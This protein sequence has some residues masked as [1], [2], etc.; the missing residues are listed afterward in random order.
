MNNDEKSPKLDLGKAWYAMKKHR[1]LY[2]R[3]LP[4]TTIVVMILSLGYPNYYRCKVTLVPEIETIDS[5]RNLGT[6][7]SF[8]RSLGIH[9]SRGNDAI[10][11]DMYPNL[12]MT[13]DFTS[14]MFDIR[15]RRDSDDYSISYYEYLRDHQK[16][17]WWC[18]AMDRFFSLFSTKEIK[19]IEPVNL[20]R[21]TREQKGIANII[22]KKVVCTIDSKT[23]I[24]SIDVTDQDPVVAALVADT[25]RQIL[26]ESLTEY[27][28]KK[29]SNYLAYIE[30]L[31]H[32][33]KQNYNKACDVYSDFMDSN[34]DVLL[35]SVK[36]KQEKLENEM[37][38]YFN[39]YNHLCEQLLEAKAKVVENTPAFTTLERATIPLEK[40][41]PP[42]FRI[43]VFITF[44]VFVLITIWVT[45]KEGVLKSL[46]RG[47]S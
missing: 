2:F 42:R 24:I 35:E 36:R 40:D 38:L 15:I 26:Q 44:F 27:R 33:A 13:L 34:H 5:Y 19:D 30:K 18:A 45:G 11:P 10:T 4:L 43:I 9:G 6:L 3:L 7:S 8:S 39:N 16:K 41:G 32:E 21:L 31:H 23:D 47:F 1:R 46:F 14:S 12:M 28:I 20:F 22:R 17:N 29:A 37:Q 25:V